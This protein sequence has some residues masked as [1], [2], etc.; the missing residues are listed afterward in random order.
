MNNAMSR[1][2]Q[3]L[4]KI[5]NLE[6]QL[7]I[8]KSKAIFATQRRNEA[9]KKILEKEAEYT[10]K[11]SALEAEKAAL[12][13]NF[14]KLQKQK[15][16]AVEKSLT[17]RRVARALV[18]MAD[19]RDELQNEINAQNKAMENGRIEVMKQLQAN[20]DEALLPSARKEYYSRYLKNLDLKNL[21]VLHQHMRFFDDQN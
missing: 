3:Y 5:H 13:T 16:S 8:E 9:E 14:T 17:Y 10:L 2:G 19:M 6:R 7:D 20:I 15:V 11:L 12:V 18:V 21:M 1:E 4:S